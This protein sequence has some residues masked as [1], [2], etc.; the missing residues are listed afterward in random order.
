MSGYTIEVDRV[1][2][3]Y[4]DF[5][6]VNEISFAVP[7]GTIFGLLGPNGAGKTTTIRMI[8][9]ITMP[10][11]GQITVMGRPST[12]T[13]GVLVGYL[14]EE[15]GLYR[16][17]KVLEHLTFLGEIRGLR[18]REARARAAAWLE[19]F[20]LAEWA[21][22]KVEELSKGMQQKLQ[23]IGCII[24]DPPVLI[25]DEPFSGLDP[26]NARTLKDLVLEM[27]DQG[28]TI[29]LSTHVMEQAER[30]CD[31]IALINNSRIVLQGTIGDVKRQYSEN[32]LVLQISGDT[33]PLIGLDGVLHVTPLNGAVE[34]ELARG[35][36]RPAFLRRAAQVV[37]IESVIPHE[38][39]LD[40]IFVRVVSGPPEEQ[41]LEKVAS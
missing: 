17:M 20:G 38:T 32:R 5:T 22:K 15:R 41:I 13:G 27:R 21:D 31:S 33:S 18:A 12:E 34:V 25:L 9:N 37:D 8:M 2:K 36:E 16:K 11:S 30:L 28:K 23:L 6:A 26:V 35:V 39:S 24:H 10:D 1:T 3:R 29:V 40:E 14:P 19:R 7:Q 4:G